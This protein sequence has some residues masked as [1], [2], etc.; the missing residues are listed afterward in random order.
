MRLTAQQMQ[1]F[2]RD[3]YLVFPNLFC[4]AE[5]A[6][7][8]AETARLSRIEAETVV[9]ERTGGVRS[10]F[11]VHEDDGATRS[12]AFRAL[13]RTP[14]VLEPTKQ[15]LGGDAYVYHTKINTKPAIEGTVWMW[16]QDYGSWKRDGC[17]RPDMATFAVMMTDSLE[18]NGALYII[19]GSHKLG[20]IEPYFDDNT[21]YK[22]WAVPKQ[23][24][25]DVLKKSPPPVPII[26]PAGTAVL[27]HCN[28]LH[29][30]GHNL[31]AE[32]RW[33]IYISFNSCANAPQ[34]GPDTR[35]D[36]VVSRN[37]APL[38]V[39]ADEGVLQAA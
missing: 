4:K 18:M 37:T 27:F 34:F 32:D 13:A 8:R 29:A 11:R 12:A 35:P 9:R 23:Q 28:T 36:W 5:I 19:P 20:R 38:P 39:E 21:S 3:G 6:V 16:H 30:S 2:D 14:R 15:V 10:I 7:L 24:M 17:P 25:L 33:H 22:F 1:Q 31:T 26:G